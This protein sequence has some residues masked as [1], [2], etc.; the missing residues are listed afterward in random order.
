MNTGCANVTQKRCCQKM[1][2]NKG[3]TTPAPRPVT[4]CGYRLFSYGECQLSAL[5]CF[6]FIIISFVSFIIYVDSYCFAATK[7]CSIINALGVTVPTPLSNCYFTLFPTC[8]HAIFTLPLP[9]NSLISFT[10]FMQQSYALRQ[11]KSYKYFLNVSAIFAN[12][13]NNLES[14]APRA[15]SNCY[16]TLFPTCATL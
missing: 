15:L 2:D 10:F 3:L 8:T 11:W 7:K 4:V 14:G 16:S 5:R 1:N 9:P 6:N 12:V 13:F